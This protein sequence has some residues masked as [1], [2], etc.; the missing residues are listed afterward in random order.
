MKFFR[1]N[2]VEQCT[3]SAQYTDTSFQIGTS[4]THIVYIH[5]YIF[6]VVCKYYQKVFI[7]VVILILD[8]KKYRILLKFADRRRFVLL[9]SVR[10]YSIQFTDNELK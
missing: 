10:S 6:Y 3:L 2:F 9:F 8:G 4:D 5:I 7:P 1:L